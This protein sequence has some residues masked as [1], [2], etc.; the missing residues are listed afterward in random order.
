[1]TWV[2]TDTEPGQNS[3]ID[4]KAS[5]VSSRHDSLVR[6]RDGCR[7]RC[8]VVKHIGNGDAWTL[9]TKKGNGLDINPEYRLLGNT[10][11]NQI[12]QGPTNRN[13]TSV[14]PGHRQATTILISLLVSP[15]FGEVTQEVG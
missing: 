5:V 10:V 11:D 8:R 2:G 15:K 3:R 14:P 4:R 7:C 1:M 12:G 13:S 6:S 9:A